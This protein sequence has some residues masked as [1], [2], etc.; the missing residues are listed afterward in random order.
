MGRAMN[1]SL[2]NV[3]FGAFGAAAEARRGGGGRARRTGSRYREITAED[4]AV[5][6]A[7][8]SRS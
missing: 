1:R 8:A 5:M 3:L 6:L 7:Y 4:A 2:A